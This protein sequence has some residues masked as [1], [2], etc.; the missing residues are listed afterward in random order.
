MAPKKLPPSPRSLLAEAKGVE[1]KI[2]VRL[3][4][5]ADVIG[6]LRDKNYSYGKIS[7]WLG[8]RLGIT[9]NRGLVHRIFTEW[10]EE[11]NRTADD[12]LYERMNEMPPTDEETTAH[13]IDAALQRIAEFVDANFPE[14]SLP[15]S[16]QALMLA[17]GHYYQT[18]AEDEAKAIALDEEQ[19]AK[20]Q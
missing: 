2:T 17:A 1:E 18:I 6:E 15:C 7:E 12:E 11:R 4:D 20:K 13:V 9:V 19:E 14:G 3:Q 5:Y 10:D 8:E 16:K